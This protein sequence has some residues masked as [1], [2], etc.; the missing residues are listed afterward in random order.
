MFKDTAAD[1]TQSQIS[2]FNTTD[3]I[4]LTDLS[5]TGVTTKY[6]GGNLTVASITGSVIISLS[7]A[8]GT[9]STGSFHAASDGGIGTMLTWI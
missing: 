7:F 1:L 9:P 6:S 2:G 5:P 3:K 4:D 8:N